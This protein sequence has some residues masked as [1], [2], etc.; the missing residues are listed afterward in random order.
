MTGVE[1]REMR[2]DS[3]LTQQDAATK[4]GVTQAYLSMVERGARAVSAELAVRVVEVFEVPATSLPLL[5][6]VRASR[7]ELYFKQALGELGYPGFAYLCGSVK[8][9][10]AEFLMRAIDTDDLDARVT[11]SLPWVIASFPALNW[12]WLLANAK[13]HDRQN[14]LAFVTSLAGDV[15]L[16]WGDSIRTEELSRRVAGLE[17]S[18]L[19]VEDTLCSAGIT[20]AERRWLRTHRTPLAAHWNLLADLTLEQ[21]DYDPI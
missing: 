3:S 11:E 6:Y 7:D 16:S 19:A 5:P 1:L 12:D 10:P 8:I 4:L 2:L 9:N 20:Q 18:R 21:V 15:A 14:R 13:V 17:R